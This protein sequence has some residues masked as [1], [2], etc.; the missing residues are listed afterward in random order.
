MSYSFQD[1]TR[2]WARVPVDNI[3]YADPNQLKSMPDDQFKEL[4]KRFEENRY[5]LT[6]WRNHQNKW[7]EYLGLDNT[8]NKTVLDFGCGF[9]MESLQ[10]V[11]AGNRVILADINR[12]S[13]ET[14][15]KCLGVH[16]FKPLQAVLVTGE[17]PFFDLADQNF[18]CDI[19]YSNGVLHHTPK[20]R[21]ILKRAC[22]NLTDDGEIRLML[23]SDVGWVIATDEQLPEVHEDVSKHPQFWRFVRFFDEV[24]TYADWYNR[25]KLEHV[26][27]DFLKVEFCEYITNDDR[28][29]VC[30]LKKK[31]P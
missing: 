21:D 12:S 22:K 27:G 6:G 11:K 25:E 28:Y 4:A 10:F 9:G 5:S 8:T 1:A 2:E 15:T 30:V 29:L 16:G 3:A 31:N 24:G 23:Y 7:R 14:A 17:E 13:L 26:V 18:S 19:F 20:F